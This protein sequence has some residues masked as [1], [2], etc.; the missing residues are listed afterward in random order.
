LDKLLHLGKKN[1]RAYFVL[2]SIFRNFALLLRKD[3]KDMI[4]VNAR[5][6]RSNQG[7][8]LDMARNGEQVV[9][10]TR[11]R[12]DFMLTYVMSDEAAENNDNAPVSMTPELQAKIEKAWQEHLDGETTVCS[13]VEEVISHYASL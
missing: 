11:H 2:P 12:G 3:D 7:K 9:L 13:S 6:F 8:F 1:K 4:V 10:R 5:D